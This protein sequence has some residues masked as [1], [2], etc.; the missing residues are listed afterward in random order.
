[1]TINNITITNEDCMLMLKRTPS[2][3]IDL[4]LTDPPYGMDFQSNHRQEKHKK[5]EGDKWE[6]F[7][8]AP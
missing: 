8:L 1:M 6:I 7:R 2:K 3:S 4:I 5:I